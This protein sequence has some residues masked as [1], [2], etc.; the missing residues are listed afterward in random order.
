[1]KKTINITD[2][3]WDEERFRD[4]QDAADFARKLGFDGLELMHLP[5]EDPSFFLPESVIGVHLRYPNDWVDLWNRNNAGL[6]L[7][8]GSLAQAEKVFGGLEREVI[9]EQL[10]KDLELAQSL[11][12]SYVVFHVCNVNTRELYSYEFSHTD[13]EVVD[14]TAELVNTLL[15][16]KHYEF[17]F[18]M[19]NLWWPGLTMT[20]PE[21]TKRLLSQIHYPRK[22]IMLDTG[23]LMHMNLDL[24]TQEEAI[25]YILDQVDAHKELVSWIRGMHLNQ[26]LTGDY[27][28]QLL[29]HREE[30]LARSYEERAGE[31]YTHIF[32][33]DSHLPFTS[34]QTSRLVERIQPEYLTFELITCDLEEH[35]RKLRQQI[36]A[37]E[38]RSLPGR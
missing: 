13:E 15:D 1:M 7:E 12:A 31:C 30:N 9:L 2:S 14:A 35:E 20:R 29:K 27:V 16:G 36:E 33:I 19:E 23:H 25:A 34:P 6:E 24:S 4:G 26:S 8:Y 10:R 11:H 18:L 28:R 3:R 38:A 17:E 21:I 37:L 5:G 22:G 32:Q